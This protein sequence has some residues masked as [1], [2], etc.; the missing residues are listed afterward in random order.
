[1]NEPLNEPHADSKRNIGE[2]TPP[3][4]D[5]RSGSHGTRGAGR[6]GRGFKASILQGGSGVYIYE[7]LGVNRTITIS[8]FLVTARGASIWSRRGDLST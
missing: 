3:T 6:A 7:V 5:N 2:A 4:L 8:Q 1:M